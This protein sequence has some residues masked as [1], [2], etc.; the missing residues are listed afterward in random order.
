MAGRVT[1]CR[2]SLVLGL[3][4]HQLQIAVLKQAGRSVQGQSASTRGRCKQGLPL[5]KQSLNAGQLCGQKCLV[6]LCCLWLPSNKH[7][8]ALPL[9]ALPRP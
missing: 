6:V 9:S 2:D 8:A 1:R 3:R 5:H 7:T 4:Q